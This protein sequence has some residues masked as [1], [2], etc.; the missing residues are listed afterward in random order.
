MKSFLYLLIELSQ[1]L[2]L[3]W[4]L[5]TLWLLIALVRRKPGTRLLRL[6][7]LALSLTT[8]T[9]L[10]SWLLAQLENRHP[11]VRIEDLPKAD[12]I[13]CLGGG[14]EPGRREPTGIHLTAG[15][16][17]RLTTAL[18]LAVR[19][20]A[21]ALVLGG[22]GSVR[23]G[24]PIAQADAIAAELARIAP[25]PVET[26]SLGLCTDTHDEAV[27]AAAL[28]QQHGWKKVLLVTSA[29]HMPRAAATFAK[30]GLEVVAVPC[31]YESSFNRSDEVSWFHL[32][33]AGGF[34]IYSAWLHEMLG[35]AA[36]R[37]RGWL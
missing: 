18:A 33:H 7:W 31:S 16:S 25:L 30:T 20:Q 8:C 9:P 10:P 17:D 32:P 35:L 3:S 22:G 36:Y 15:G 2:T 4:L 11:A 1:P 28:A 21:P 23:G 19:Q 26:L 5:L 12:F 13:V 27:K 37:A 14:M 24:K 6:A 29:S 34:S